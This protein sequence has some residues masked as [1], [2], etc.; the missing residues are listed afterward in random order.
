MLMDSLWEGL[1]VINGCLR[2]KVIV[3]EF[4][5]SDCGWGMGIM[6]VAGIHILLVRFPEWNPRYAIP[7]A[8]HLMPISV[9]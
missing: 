8:L 2:A 4:P 3:M 5:G 1:V 6:H 7:K 9:R